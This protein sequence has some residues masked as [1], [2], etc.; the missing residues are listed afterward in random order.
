MNLIW[1]ILYHR[2]SFFQSC[3]AALNRPAW[4]VERNSLQNTCRSRIWWKR[5]LNC[6]TS[7][8]VT[9]LPEDYLLFIYLCFYA[10]FVSLWPPYHYDSDILLVLFRQRT[11]LAVSPIFSF[12]SVLPTVFLLFRPGSFRSLSWSFWVISKHCRNLSSWCFSQQ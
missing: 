12:T 5:S 1:H 6:I 9:T 10:I 4:Q 2:A 7:S 11:I 3:E 8:I